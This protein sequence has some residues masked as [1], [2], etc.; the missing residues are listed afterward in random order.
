MRRILWN[1]FWE[2]PHKIR[3]IPCV[4]FGRHLGK[5]WF[6]IET[7]NKKGE[8]FCSICG[9]GALAKPHY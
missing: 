7:I 3:A 4:K 2:L 1:L 6:G 9:T 5:N 8:G